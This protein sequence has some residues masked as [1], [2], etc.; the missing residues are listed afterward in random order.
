M[1]RKTAVRLIFALAMAG[2][3][4]GAAPARAFCIDNKTQHALRVHMVTA[5]PMG[6]F[7]ELFQPR[8]RACCAW[9]DQRCNPTRVRDGLLTFTIRSKR[10]A[11]RKLYCQ[12]GWARQV[13]A[14]ANGDIVITENG[15]NLGGLQCD[16]RDLQKRPVTQQTFLQRH[17]KRGMPPPIVVPPPPEG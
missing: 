6:R 10:K 14:T 16:S 3:L 13:Y 5:N 9:F 1:T 17:R 8:Q 4:A 2:S 15:S 7:V 12:S 11:S